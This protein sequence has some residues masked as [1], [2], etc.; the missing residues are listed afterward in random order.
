MSANNDNKANSS[1]VLGLKCIGAAIGIAVFGFG[2]KYLIEK[3]RAAKSDE[4]LASTEPEKEN[5]ELSYSS[6]DSEA[7]AA[8]APTGSGPAPRVRDFG[9]FLAASAANNCKKKP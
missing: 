2:T 1:L 9:Y 8:A 7:P 3:V 5:E 4:L 6:S